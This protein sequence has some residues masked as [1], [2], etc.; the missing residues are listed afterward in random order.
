M[1]DYRITEENFNILKNDIQSIINRLNLSQPID[2][3]PI[4]PVGAPKV[5]WADECDGP[6]GAINTDMWN[7]QTGGRWGNGRDLQQY[8]N[9]TKNI[10]Y[11]GIGHMIIETHRETFVGPDGVSRDYTSAR[12]DGEGK[13][14]DLLTGYYGVVAKVPSARGIWPALWTAGGS[15]TNWPVGGE[16]DMLET[17]GIST[18]VH[19]TVHAEWGQAGWSGMGATPVPDMSTN[20]HEYGVFF[21]SEFIQFYIDR[22]P[23]LKVPRRLPW[24]WGNIPQYML[25]FQAVGGIGG[26]PVASDYPKQLVVKSIRAWDKVPFIGQLPN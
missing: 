10:R 23:K 11:D 18:T 9:R 13:R 7:I 19:Q 17:V 14:K 16:L 5:L 25:L 22:V 6:Y 3:P 26:T 1:P 21:N 20:F 4:P 24:P 2:T 12:I 15:L 8:T